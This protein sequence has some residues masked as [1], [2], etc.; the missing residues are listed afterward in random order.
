MDEDRRRSSYP[1]AGLVG[2]VPSVREW[3]EICGA[4]QGHAMEHPHRAVFR[5]AACPERKMTV[6]DRLNLFHPGAKTRKEYFFERQHTR[7]RTAFPASVSLE[8]G[9]VFEGSC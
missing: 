2:Q 6:G 7:K 5:A 1:G 3:T 8:Q 4:L 9:T